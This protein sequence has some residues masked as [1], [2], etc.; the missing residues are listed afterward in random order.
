MNRG[1]QCRSRMCFRPISTEDRERGFTV[2]ELMV[3]VLIIAILIATAVPSYA[4][5]RRR[6]ND[7]AAQTLIRNALA[8]QKVVYT[9]LLRYADDSSGE[10]TELEPGLS[11]VNSVMP[12][13]PGTVTVAVSGSD[14]VYLSGKSRSGTCFYLV[15]DAALGTGYAKDNSCRAADIQSYVTGGW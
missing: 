6:T 1:A 9:G 13:A 2:I 11:Y 7:R 12:G 3:V 5:A 8:L 14:I 4:G 15:D 10:L